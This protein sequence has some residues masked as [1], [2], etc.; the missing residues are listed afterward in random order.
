M[1][2]INK[3]DGLKKMCGI[4]LVKSDWEGMY[5]YG[6]GECDQQEK[7]RRRILKDTNGLKKLIREE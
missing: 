4:C 1:V 5:M 3:F 2:F 7:T 6:I